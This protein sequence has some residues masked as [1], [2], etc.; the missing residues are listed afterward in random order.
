MLKVGVTVEEIIKKDHEAV[1]CLSRNILNLSSYARIIHKRVEKATKKPVKLT[2]IIMSLSRLQRKLEGENPLLQDVQIDGLTVKTPLAEIVF[3]KTPKTLSL[4]ATLPIS[5]QPREDE[6]F[7]FS[8]NSRGVI[9]LCS[10]SK[11]KAVTEHMKLKPV[12]LLKNLSAI[13]I[14]ISDKYH[15]EPNITFSLIHRIAERKIP[16][17]ETITTWT[18]IVFVCESKYLSILLEIFKSDE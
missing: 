17:V 14:A 13:G 9:I 15:L 2:T 7:S 18:E 8:Q 6:W 3:D 10:E 4:L 11:L 16:L 12:L 1:F 5:V